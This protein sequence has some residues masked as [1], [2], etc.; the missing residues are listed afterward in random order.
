LGLKPE[1]II[2]IGGEVTKALVGAAQKEGYIDE[3]IWI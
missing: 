3:V 1:L 2:F